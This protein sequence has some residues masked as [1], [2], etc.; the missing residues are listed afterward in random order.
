M[1]DRVRL[2][3]IGLKAERGWASAAHVPALRALSDDIEVVGVANTNHASAEAAARALGLGRAFDSVDSLVAS[4]DVDVVAVT[5]KVP[6]HLDLVTK[7]LESGKNVYCEWPLGKGLAEAHELATLA[8]RKQAVAVVGTQAVVSPEVLFVRDLVADGFVGEVRS[9]T[10]VGSGHTWGD[11]VG[12]GDAY[13]MDSKNGATLLSVIAG[14]AFSAM[15]TVL[16]PVSKVNG[17]LSQRRSTVRIIETGKAIPMKTPDQVIVAAEFDSGVPL[18]FQLRGGLPCG[19]R[20][21]WEISG[22]K[23]DMRISAKVEEI[24]VINISPLRVEAGKRGEHGFSEIEVPSS[25][26]FGLEDAPVAR[27]VAGIYR[28]MARDVGQGTRS[29]PDFDVAVALH[30]IL[31]AV[32]LSSRTGERQQIG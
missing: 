29:A 21:M 4:P 3:I 7:A 12:A 13:A 17:L 18:A 28:L 1:K 5:V 11:E 2:G 30:R 20:L 23:G 22:S 31:D 10:Y 24:P 14:H 26:Y 9:T 15:Q 8:K 32:E 27:N 16:G 25:Y 6:H 19:T